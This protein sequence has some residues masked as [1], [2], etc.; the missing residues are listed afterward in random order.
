[1][2]PGAVVL[3]HHAA[4][5]DHAPHRGGLRCGPRLFAVCAVLRVGVDDRRGVVRWAG[6]IRTEDLVEG[7]VG[8]R[9]PEVD[10][11]VDSAAVGR[12]GE[13]LDGAIDNRVLGHSP[14]AGHLGVVANLELERVGACSICAW[15]EENG[16]ALAVKLTAK[17]HLLS[18]DRVDGRLD[19]ILRHARIEHIDIRTEVRLT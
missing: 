8:Q 4:V 7:Q 15:L 18:R 5:D 19:L 9:A 13:H 16:V 14:K 17:G 12:V 1:M 2:V 6:R 3:E 11:G 10:S